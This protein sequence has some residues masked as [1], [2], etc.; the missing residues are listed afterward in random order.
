M[1]KD[2]EVVEDIPIVPADENDIKYINLAIS[3]CK[4]S[5]D[6]KT[7]VDLATSSYIHSGGSRGGSLG[8][9]EPPF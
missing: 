5:K 6:S 4:K 9:N 3:L 7:Q 8:S 2:D 1:G